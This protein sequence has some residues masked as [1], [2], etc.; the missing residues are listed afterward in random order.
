MSPRSRGRFPQN[1]SLSRRPPM[2][3]EPTSARWN[4]MVTKGAL[5]LG[6]DGGGSRCRARIEDEYGA[7]LGEGSSGPATTRLGIDQAWRSIL[8][9][10]AAA[11]EQAGIARED[12]AR[13][14]AGI[15]L[16]GL[17]RRGAQAA[18]EQ[19]AHPFAS[20]RFISDG[21]A[22]CLGAP[23]GVVGAIVVADTG[24]C[25]ASML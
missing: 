18:L 24:A 3:P 13:L 1:D 8:Q 2:A 19:L 20:V 22:S 15:G 17:G 21:L 14:H 7:A 5:Y 12:F 10:C 9:A 6:I 23:V 25:R 4:G 11:A 16:S